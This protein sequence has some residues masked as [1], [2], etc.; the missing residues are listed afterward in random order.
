MRTLVLLLIML[1]TLGL[2]SVPAMAGD[3]AVIQSL[4]ASCQP[5]SDEELAN[6]KGTQLSMPSLDLRQVARCIYS[7]LP[8][9]AQRD[10]MRVAEAIR[11]LRGGDMVK[12][13]R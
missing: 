2:C 1:L 12:V 7:K 6:M 3:Q 10:I 8:P 13:T 11:I 9:E 5:V 4:P